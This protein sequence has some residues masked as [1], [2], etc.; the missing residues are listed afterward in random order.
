MERL[1]IVVGI[2]F[3]E[4]AAR[5]VV[6]ARSLAS[7]LAGELVPVFVHQGV[8]EREW[9]LGPA[10]RAWLEAL[11]LDPGSLVVRRGLPWVELVRLAEKGCADFIVAGSHGASG[12][13]PVALGS[14]AARL[15]ILSPFPVVLVSPRGG[16]GGAVRLEA[17]PS[18]GAVV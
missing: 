5:A 9:C 1:R 12:F 2:D 11:S 13:Q 3:S 6:A 8:R 10:E 15:A 16:R 4:G 17:S 18:G 14:T 7:R